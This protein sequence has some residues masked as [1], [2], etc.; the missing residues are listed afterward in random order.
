LKINLH[1]WDKKE[2]EN[3]AISTEVILRYLTS[4]KQK[5]IA[6]WGTLQE[7]INSIMREMKEEV[8]NGI[9]VAIQQNMS[10][11]S[12]QAQEDAWEELTARWA[13]P[14][15]LVSGKLFFNRLSLWTMENYGISISARQVIPYFK[16]DE[17]PYEIKIVI[18][19]IMDGKPL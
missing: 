15:D 11:Q 17:V 2:I 19:S 8:L 12:E 1:I 18:D 16:P 13:E 10:G 9:T 4:C 5:G 14:S 6:A 3:Y 7:E